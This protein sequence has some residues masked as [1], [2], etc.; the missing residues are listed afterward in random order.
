M[1][2]IK[3]GPGTQFDYNVRGVE[4]EV[5]QNGE[6]VAKYIGDGSGECI[7]PALIFGSFSIREKNNQSLEL[8]GE[9]LCR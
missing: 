2:K 9:K 3:R 4:F 6:V 1:G 8:T 5:I 7:V